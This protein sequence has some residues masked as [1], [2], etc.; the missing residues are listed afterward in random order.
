MYYKRFERRLNKLW[1]N[2]GN[3]KIS[4]IKGD[5]VLEEEEDEGLDCYMHDLIGC[6]IGLFMVNYFLAMIDKIYSS[7]YKY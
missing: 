3:G 7:F 6:C 5:E 1:W 2:F 4:D